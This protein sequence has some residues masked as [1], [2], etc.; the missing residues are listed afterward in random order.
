MLHPSPDCTDRSPA[1]PESSHSWA[2]WPKV[3][4]ALTARACGDRL[5]V[6]GDHST[7]TVGGEWRT[8][9]LAREDGRW[10]VVET[11]TRWMS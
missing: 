7:G 2:D 6:D 9:T 4:V 1:R 10:Q 3:N 11:C 8:H 5:V